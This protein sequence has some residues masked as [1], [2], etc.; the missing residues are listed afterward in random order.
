LGLLVVMNS[1]LAQT[2]T[3]TG[4]PFQTWYSVVS[5]ADGTKLFAASASGAFSSIYTSTNSGE[6]W[7][8]T[9]VLSNDWVLAVSSAD[10]T[11]LLAVP[12]SD[13]AT[14]LYHSTN[15]GVNWSSNNAPSAEWEALASSA[16]GTKLVA[17]GSDSSGSFGVVYTSTDS[18][19][20]WVS[21][22]LPVT[23]LIWNSVSSSADGNK[24]VVVSAY[25]QICIST[26]AGATWQQPVSAPGT[27]N[28]WNTVASSADGSKLV[29][30][31][32]YLAQANT[33]SIYTSTNSGLTWTSNNAP[34]LQWISVASSADGTRLVAVGNH[35]VY[36]STNAGTVWSQQSTGNYQDFVSV[37]MTADGD[38]MFAINGGSTGGFFFGAGGSVYT[39]GFIPSPVLQ[40]TALPAG[41]LL[42]WTVPST[43]FVLQQ[44]L[45]LTTANWVTLTNL[46]T[47]NFTNLQD[48]VLLSPSNTSGF[49]RLST[50]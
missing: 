21:N 7:T 14:P 29:A 20:T 44:N 38:R 46:P 35:A 11:K 39:A 16:D 4:A 33:G 47:L 1:A 13:P 43:N 23:P 27:N 42:S 40:P 41:L 18:G 50:P 5:S 9:L 8:Q 31:S 32:E 25:G 2:W 48:Q 45:D 19:N 36:F 15:S 17:V 6:A 30:V 22:S 10:G 34:S 24:L 12:I 28:Y 3:N 26:N 37:A 49:Y